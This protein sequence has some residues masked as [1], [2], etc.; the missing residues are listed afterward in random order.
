MGADSWEPG[1]YD[2]FAVEREQP[3]WDLC[4]LVQPTAAPRL[5]DLGCGDGRLTVELAR[6]LHAGTAVG[7]D[8]SPAMLAR[9]AARAASAV[10]FEAGDL[11]TWSAA[12]DVDVVFS[13]AALQWVP[14]HRAVLGRWRRSLA[15]GGQ[16]AVQVPANADHPSHRVLAALAERWLGDQ[17]PPDPVAAHVLTP[18]AYAVLLH[19]LGFAHRHVRLQVYGHL[20]DSPAEVVEWVKGTTLTRIR[21]VLPAGEYEAFVH[22]YRRLLLAELGERRPFLYPFKRILLWGRLA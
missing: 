4:A 11:A 5:V 1:Q 17:A 21:A 22:E 16:M 10:R 18:E 8:S 13:N 3:F 12:G 19:Q 15:P 20:L 9:C 14:D 6:R 7:V 2:R